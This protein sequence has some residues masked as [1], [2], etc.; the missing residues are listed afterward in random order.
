MFAIALAGGR[1]VRARPL[2]LTTPD[3]LRSKAA[4]RV[5]GRSLIEWSVDLLAA[6]GVR[7]FYIAACGSENRGQIKSI[8]DYGDRLGVS[9]RYSRMRFDRH[10]TGSGEATLRCLEH[11]NLDGP[12]LVFPTDSLFEFDLPAMAGEHRAAGA[13]VTVAAVHRSTVQAEGKYGVLDCDSDGVVSRF[14]E[15]PD[16]MTARSLADRHGQVRTNAGMYLIDGARLRM[17]ARDPELTALVRSRLDWGRDLLPYLVSCG[18]RVTSHVIDRFGDLGSPS[19]FLDTLRDVLHDKYPQVSD[20]MGARIHESSLYLKD[21]VSSRTL[22]EKI[23]DGSVRVGDN[24]RIGRD[25]EIG[26]GVELFDSDIGDGVDVGAGAKLHRVSCGDHS[27]IGPGARLSDAVVGQMV[28]IRSERN[29]PV[30]LVGYCA[31]GD[32]VRVHAGLQLRGVSIFPRLEVWS[33][34]RVPPGTCLIEPRDIVRW[35]PRS[36]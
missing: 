8:L 6:Q 1:G 11:W 2:T 34:A 23:R 14:V 32:E 33:D 10:N 24:V 16:R 22:A 12:G 31:L 27:I 17:A 15:K 28:E 26:P 30:V 29:H 5:A 36:A 25:V 18:H 20:R 9:V 7:D 3:Y 4:M 19:D 35:S 21:S 13:A